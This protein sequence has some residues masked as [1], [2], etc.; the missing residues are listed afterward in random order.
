MEWNIK[1]KSTDFEILLNARWKKSVK[2]LADKG[3]EYSSDVDRLHN[4]KA[5]GRK[6]NMTPENALMGIKVKQDVSVDDIVKNLDKG[7]LPSRALMDE[8]IGDS[9]NYLVLL[10][11]LIIERIENEVR[12]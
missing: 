8:K 6:R 11:A 10:E 1:M 2:T 5:A 12:K 9:I 7:I 4:F 3:N